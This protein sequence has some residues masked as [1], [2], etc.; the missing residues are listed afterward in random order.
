MR[1]STLADHSIVVV[2][3]L[4]FCGC[5]AIAVAQICAPNIP[6][7]ASDSS[8]A[9]IEVVSAASYSVVDLFSKP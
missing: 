4:A 7:P 2:S 1:M 6:I 5:A 9:N 3:I 8:A